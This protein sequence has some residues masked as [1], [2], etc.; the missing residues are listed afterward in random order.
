MTDEKMTS[1]TGCKGKEIVCPKPDVE[2]CDHYECD[3]AATSPDK[4]CIHIDECA[5]LRE[6]N[7]KYECR[8]VLCD[9]LR[10]C[11]VEYDDDKCQNEFGKGN[12]CLTYK[13]SRTDD[14]IK[15]GF[16]KTGCYLAV[17]KTRDLEI[18][19]QASGM[20]E[21]F[22][23]NCDTNTGFTVKE[24]VCP[25]RLNNT[26]CYSSE[27]LEV[28]PNTYG[29]VDFAEGRS[30]DT[31]CR[32][33]E[34]HGN[35]GWVPIIATTDEDCR[36]EFTQ[37]NE[38]L[39]KEYRCKRI[40]CSDDEDK[41][42]AENITECNDIC[43]QEIISNCTA[44]TVRLSSAEKCYNFK[45]KEYK[46]NATTF[47]GRCN[48][49]DALASPVNCLETELYDK[50]KYNNTE[51]FNNTQ[52][53]S[54]FC[55]KG[56]CS[57][58]CDSKPS[59]KGN[60]CIDFNCTYISEGQWKWVQVESYESSHCF[61]NDCWHKEC[62]PSV[63]CTNVTEICES[64]SNDCYS[65]H[66]NYTKMECVE[67]KLL[68]E[69]ECTNETC[70][71]GKRVVLDKIEWCNLTEKYKCIDRKCVYDDLSRTS[72]CEYFDIEP[73]GSDD[74]MIYSCDNDTG[75]WKESPKCDD[76]IFCTE[77]VCTIFGECKYPNITCSELPME[78]YSCFER[79]CKE[80][81]E[82]SNYKCY[83]KLIRNA[84]VDICGQCITE[85]D[86]EGSNSNDLSSLSSSSSGDQLVNCANAPPRPLL[87]EG[88]AAASIALI[89][90]A[91]IVVGAA[92]TASGVMGT[93]TLISRAKSAN[94]TS[95]H[96]NPLFETA[97]TEMTN[98]AFAGTAI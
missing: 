43:T 83:R 59:T 68:I 39:E 5:E 62:V 20:I 44:T 64:K 87:T 80:D 12:K 91:A 18:Q 31:Y 72:K 16:E 90:L 45:C 35:D 23:P 25:S 85:E 79:R 88:L 17:N 66:C 48:D 34:C 57:K 61:S 38:T 92:V 26:V 32:R 42:I 33:Y 29:C 36:T 14:V 54:V 49:E 75:D 78:G 28:G 60:K 95:A 21:C 9:S 4:V 81:P 58:K 15:P 86:E 7:N 73:S 8:T 93:K 11:R 50:I 70:V 55:D 82:N 97:E 96:T 6:A 65:Y 74:C 30:P 63:G 13:C 94:N 67:E 98:P 76:G 37:H 71:N 53:C 47:E 3:P 1:S 41:C 24:D 40:Y 77:N 56:T 27:C 69:S 51:L 19:L 2:R 10:G 22:I 89:I 46:V 84:Y 52:C